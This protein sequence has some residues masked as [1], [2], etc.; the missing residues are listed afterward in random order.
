M[1][2]KGVTS[3]RCF[4]GWSNRVVS[5]NLKTI[6]AVA[7]TAFAALPAPLVIRG[8]EYPVAVLDIVIAAE[9]ERLR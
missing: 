2:R 7:A 3:K 1:S 6:R 8:G 5:G 4:V 9:N